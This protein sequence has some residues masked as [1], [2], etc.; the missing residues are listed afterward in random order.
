MKKATHKFWHHF[1]N[2][3]FKKKLGPQTMFCANIVHAQSS[4][5]RPSLWNHIYLRFQNMIKIQYLNNCIS[6]SQRI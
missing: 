5:T 4:L 6:K 1:E 2:K 3:W